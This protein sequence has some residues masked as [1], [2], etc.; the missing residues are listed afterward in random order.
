MVRAAIVGYGNI[1]KASYEALEAA[2]DMEI[3]GVVLRDK[4]KAQEKGVPAGA[5]VVEDIR[6]LNSVDVALL[7][8]P[9]LSVPNAN[10]KN[11]AA[12]LLALGINTIDSFDVHGDA[13]LNL[14]EK[15]DT[16]GKKHNS[17]AIIGAG[18]DPGIDSMI[19]G[20]F[21]FSAPRGLTYT[22]FGP[23]MS[24]GHT[25]AVKAIEGVKNALSVTVPLGQGLHRRMVYIE[26]HAG[27]EFSEVSA[28]IKKD[29]YF[30]KDETHVMQ[31]EDVS[32]LQDMGHG[33]HMERKGV[34]GAA[35][36][37]LFTFDMRINNPA[38]TAQIM[39]AAARA[40]LRQGAGCYTLPEI[41]I[42]HML[43]VTREELIR[44][45]V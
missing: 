9:S 41:P 16:A 40:S 2:K 32:A 33:V 4:T 12:H 14:C 6:E 28:R 5:T 30:V 22:N 29:P 23:G 37:Q 39:V 11:A 21:E 10:E 17:V 7:C 24:M 35:D 45:F 43:P 34:S 42:A 18:W 36:N 1:G 44:R 13:M 20:I 26:L 27:H 8:I 25:V 19:R 38:L 3:A 15:L 31:V